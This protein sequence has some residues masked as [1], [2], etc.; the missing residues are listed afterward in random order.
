MA[1]KK[2]QAGGGPPSD[3]AYLVAFGSTMTILLALFIVLSTLAQT[4]EGGF[5]AGTG[6]FTR[7]LD[8]FGFS[9]WF[10]GTRSALPDRKVG[11]Q[12]HVEQETS[13][14][15]EPTNQVNDIEQE[16]ITRLLRDMRRR[17][18]SSSAPE[19]K[20][21]IAVLWLDGSLQTDRGGRVQLTR[22]QLEQL[23]PYLPALL[24]RRIRQAY[25]EVLAPDSSPGALDTG[26]ALARQL[27]EAIVELAAG[28]GGKTRRLV[29]IVRPAR[30]S[31]TGYRARVLL[32]R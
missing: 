17:F 29:P 30:E 3:E 9:G 27:S 24:D 6:A 1:R 4:H 22:Q 32:V 18:E 16:R 8:T 10:D 19:Q 7:A 20:V 25:V 23:L 2:K 28:P 13:R 12:Y 15:D 5:K 31:Q 21:R 11:P 14:E 26:L